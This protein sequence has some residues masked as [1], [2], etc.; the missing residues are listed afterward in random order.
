MGANGRNQ[1]STKTYRKLVSF[2][3]KSP[4]TSV[5]LRENIINLGILYSSSLLHPASHPS[6]PLVP[7]RFCDMMLCQGF[8]GCGLSCVVCHVCH[9]CHG[10]SFDVTSC[11]LR[12]NHYYD[13]TPCSSNV[14]VVLC[15]V[16]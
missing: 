4:E 5:S 10:L 8:P 9:V 7:C 6:G 15:S 12:F 13:Q 2:L 3:Q 14:V 1:V 11:M 16:V